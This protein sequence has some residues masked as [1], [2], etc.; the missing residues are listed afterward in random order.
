MA[1]NKRYAISLFNFM[2]FF[3]FAFFLSFDSAPF[4]LLFLFSF[5][6]PFLL[7]SFPSFLSFLFY[8]FLLFLL[9][10]LLL[11]LLFIPK[12]SDMPPSLP[13]SG[14]ARCN[15][16]KRSDDIYA[17]Y[18]LSVDCLKEFERNFILKLEWKHFRFAILVSRLGTW[19]PVW[20]LDYPG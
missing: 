5:L 7:S 13:S 2:T 10:F 12:P 4:S 19:S 20:N 15:I 8:F 1:L 6:F 17:Y 18:V 3:L 14:A 16:I 11:F 9:F